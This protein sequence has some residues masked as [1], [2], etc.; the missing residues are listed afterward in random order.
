MRPAPLAALALALLLAAAALVYSRALDAGANYDEGVY[1]ASMDALAAGDELGE[2]VFASQPPGFYVFLRVADLAAGESVRS[3]RIVFLVA[4]V[5]GLAAA[6]ALGRELG[7]VPGGLAAAAVLAVAPPYPERAAQVEAETPA[8]ALALA[9]LALAARGVRAS[10]VF[11]SAAA[12]AL[13][14]ASVSVKLLTVTAAVPFFGLALALRPRPR[15]LVAAAAGALALALVV[16]LAH[17]GALAD[18]WEGAVAF[19]ERAREAVGGAGARENLERV[20]R[21]LDPRTPFAWLVVAGLAAALLLR[22]A[23]LAALWLWPLAASVFL[24]WHRP[25]LD[26]HLVLL[27]VALAVAAGSALGALLAT[28]ERLAAPAAALAALFVA[29]GLV[30]EARRLDDA[31]AERRDVV[32]AAAMLRERTRRTDVV[33]ADLPIVPFLARRRVPGVLVDTSIVRFS[34]RSLTPRSAARALRAPRVRA[35]VV[36][37]AFASYPELMAS[38]RRSF[39]ASRRVGEITL[40][41]RGPRPA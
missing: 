28:G 24:V 11:S 38:V 26:H 33:A 7:G 5:A 36:G 6:F 22:R 3:V 23:A 8:L 10:A 4:A 20:L 9:G 13:L 31:R 30:Q 21:F 16:L 14:A 1:L 40:Y 19:H 29:V 39:P 41:F 34:T 37:R 25:L 32:A 12:G 15:A 27:A 2:D 35:V 18:L 17:A